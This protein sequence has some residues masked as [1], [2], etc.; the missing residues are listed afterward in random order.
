MNLT[1]GCEVATAA[2]LVVCVVR[3]ARRQLRVKAVSGT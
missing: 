3:E 2:L 1:I